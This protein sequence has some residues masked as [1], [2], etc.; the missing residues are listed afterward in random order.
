MVKKIMAFESSNQEFVS[1][2]YN[3]EVSLVGAFNFD[4]GK[5]RY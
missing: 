5:I 1:D 4:K 3:S 2:K